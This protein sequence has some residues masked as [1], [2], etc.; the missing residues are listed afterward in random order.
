MS[1]HRI[2]TAQRHN[3][4]FCDPGIIWPTDTGFGSKSLQK[5]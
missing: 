5:K 3:K 1:T 2:G 4:E